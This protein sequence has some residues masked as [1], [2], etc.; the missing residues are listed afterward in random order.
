MAGVARLAAA[1]G[2][3][4][5]GCGDVVVHSAGRDGAAQG[6]L[7]GGGPEFCPGGG[8]GDGGA[9]ARLASGLRAD[10]APL[11]G[12]IRRL[13]ARLPAGLGEV[14]TPA[15]LQLALTSDRGLCSLIVHP[16]LDSIGSLPTSMKGTKD[17]RRAWAFSRYQATGGSQ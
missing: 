4:S 15:L 3:G 11:V 5:D 2:C 7:G 13:G 12:S 6:Q 1:H 14:D 16:S 10:I 17:P 9:A 8:S